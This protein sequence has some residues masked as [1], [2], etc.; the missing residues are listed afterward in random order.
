MIIKHSELLC[1]QKSE[2]KIL[3]FIAFIEDFICAR[4]VLGKLCIILFDPHRN[5]R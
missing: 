3:T 4:F 2:G 1:F 5:L